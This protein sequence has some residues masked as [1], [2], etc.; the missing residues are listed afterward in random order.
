[1]VGPNGSGKTNLLEA[2]HVVTQGFSPRTR[3]D[4]QLIRFGAEAA[5]VSVSGRRGATPVTVDLDLA[6]RERK[7]ARLNG[8]A[9]RSSEQLR[10]ELSTLVFT[11]DRLAVV[12]SGPAVRRAYFDRTLGRLF[13]TRAGLPGGYL[14]AL[15]QRN[16][17]LRGL[18]HGET[19]VEALAPWT[20]QVVAL[21]QE[22]RDERARVIELLGPRF[23]AVAQEFGLPACALQYEGAPFSQE[24]LEARLDRDRER[25]TTGAGPHLD[26]IVIASG[27][28]DLRTFGSQGEQRMAVLSLL[29][30]EA[31]LLVE[32]RG[33]TP[34][35]LLDDVLSELDSD[36]RRALARRLEPL[37]QALLTAT[38]ESA[39]PVPAA[40]LIRVSPGQAE[41][42]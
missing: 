7:Q 3:S 4:T 22:L 25:G 39:L 10:S 8:A 35:V 32:E 16:A 27:T 34:L 20:A 11:P 23:A 9:L 18:S 28:R 26:E 13:P 1:V 40:Q 6:T 29:L 5:R 19:S 2:L 24:V 33:I 41:A 42:A 30:A 17:A 21:G 31:D 38:A 36:R 14:Q 12:K 37:G 15:G